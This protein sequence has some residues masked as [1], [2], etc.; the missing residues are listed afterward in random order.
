MLTPVARELQTELEPELLRGVPLNLCMSGWAKHFVPPD[1]GMFKVDHS[2]YNL[3]SQTEYYDEFLSHDWETSRWYKLCTML[4]IYNSRAAFVCSLVVSIAVGV[5]R[6]AKILPDKLWIQLSVFAVFPLVL[7]FWQR[8]R[9]IFARPLVVFLD[10]LCIAQHDEELKLKGIF[11]LAGFLDHSRQLTIF[12]SRRYFSRLWCTYEVGTFL[13]AKQQKPILVI[14]VKL[15]V[16]LCLFF[17]AELVIMV[18]YFM[19]AKL[20][21]ESTVNDLEE[22]FSFFLLF[23]LFY[24]PCLPLLFYLGIGMM[25]DLKELP[26]QLREFRVQDAKCFC[27]SHQHRHPDTGEVLP[28]DRQLMFQMLQKWFG[29]EGDLKEEHLEVF[30]RLVHEDLAPRVLRSVGSD[31]LP[32]NYSMYMV[33]VN[34]LPGLCTL[35]PTLVAGPPDSFNILQHS[36]WASREIMNW[37]FAGVVV[38]YALRLSMRGWLIAVRISPHCPRHNRVICSILMPVLMSVMLA[39]QWFSF[40]LALSHSEQ[41]SLL[42]AIPFIAWLVVLSCFWSWGAPAAS[43]TAGNAFAA[44]PPIF[45]EEVLCSIDVDGSNRKTDD[46]SAS[47]FS[48]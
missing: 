46:D 32:F 26:Q 19:S 8:I 16:I 43:S 18:G 47:T 33:V 15:A 2:N 10:K 20:N 3:S 30:N 14:P 40:Q 48:T 7:C 41:D 4:M 17:V 11:G 25:S 38:L 42:P 6:A 35:I 12:W 13:R 36:I 37:L 39:T 45:K 29:K 9:I 22:L 34:T 27:C 5:L 23:S 1:P 24:M 31:A 21:L 28:C 44:E